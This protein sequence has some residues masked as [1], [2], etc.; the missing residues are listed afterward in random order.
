M[1]GNR[2]SGRPLAVVTS[3]GRFLAKVPSV[4][5]GSRVVNGRST[6][7]SVQLPSAARPAARGRA[8]N[9]ATY[10][11]PLRHDV[12]PTVVGD[13]VGTGPLSY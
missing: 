5:G 3:V 10:L 2:W 4:I 12:H 11:C 13:G 8:P 1:S 6:Y 9:A 7:D